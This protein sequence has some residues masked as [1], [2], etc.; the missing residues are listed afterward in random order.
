MYYCYERK[1]LD[2]NAD[3]QCCLGQRHRGFIAQGIVN[4]NSFCSRQPLIMTMLPT[5]KSNWLSVS[6]ILAFIPLSW[7]AFHLMSH[8]CNLTRIDGLD[9]GYLWWRNSHFDLEHWYKKHVKILQVKSRGIVFVP[10]SAWQCLLWR[11]QSKILEWYR[12]IV[13][14]DFRFV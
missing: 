3:C 6:Y 10:C 12:N 8:V 5:N 13:A 7:N 4:C 9:F 2:C 11:F 14:G 1:A